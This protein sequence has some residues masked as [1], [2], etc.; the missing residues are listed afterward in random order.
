MFPVVF[1]LCIICNCRATSLTPWCGYTKGH[2]MQKM[3]GWILPC[4]KATTSGEMSWETG[5]VL[6][7]QIFFSSALW[8]QW[9]SVCLHLV[10]WDEFQPVFKSLPCWDLCHI[11]CGF[12]WHIGRSVSASRASEVPPDV[13]N[14]FGH[15]VTSLYSRFK[16][17][18]AMQT[19]CLNLFWPPLKA[20]CSL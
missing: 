16:V 11:S 13:N 4:Q 12:Y 18:D 14:L 1:G 15:D 10:S 3:Q 2:F 5:L 8:L 7:H 9:D 20:S 17:G 19:V 6:A